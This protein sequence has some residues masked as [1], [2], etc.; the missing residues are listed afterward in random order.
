MSLHFY[1]LTLEYCSITKGRITGI[2]IF[3]RLQLPL[4]DS[5]ELENY[6]N[7]VRI[8]FVL[9]QDTDK[10]TLDNIILESPPNL[11]S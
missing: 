7:P 2:H 3:G 5:S 1:P 11:T 9:N 10:L 4:Q 6:S 8:K